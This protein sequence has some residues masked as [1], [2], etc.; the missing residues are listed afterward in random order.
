MKFLDLV[1]KRNSVRNY[2]S[3]PVPGEVIER[4]LEA[5]RLS[6]SACNAQPWSFIVVA[7]AALRKRVAEA[8][9]APPYNLNTFA[10]KAPVLIV[11]VT[12]R[13]KYVTRVAGYFRG[14]Q[15]S[16]VD[17]AIACEHLVLQAAEEEV[18]TCWLGWFNE[19]RVKKILNI[20]KRKKVDIIISM[21]YPEKKEEREKTRRPIE[22]IR[23][24]L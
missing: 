22:K 1:K 18:G 19:K 17:V 11:V 20:P 8:A 2:S 16:L 14:I 15:F 13:T 23:R 24:Y 3:R 4:C 7:D 12:E 10:A 9:F 21:G 5:A 6:P